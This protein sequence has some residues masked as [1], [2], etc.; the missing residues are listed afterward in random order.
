MANLDTTNIC[1]VLLNFDE[2]N[3]PKLDIMS[4]KVLYILIKLILDANKSTPTTICI[5][6]YSPKL[7]CY[8]F[9]RLVLLQQKG[10][11]KKVGIA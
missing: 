11:N 2:Q 4:V 8:F 3:C 9:K 6:F 7:L 5:D 1:R 10:I